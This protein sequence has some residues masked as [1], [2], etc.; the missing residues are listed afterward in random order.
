MRLQALVL[1]MLAGGVAQAAVTYAKEVSRILA[2]HCEQCHRPGDIGPMPLL[3]Y[4]DAVDYAQDIKR[5]VEAGLMPP[6]KP[7]AS[8]GVFKGTFALKPEEKADLLTWIANGTPLGNEEDLPPKPEVKGAWVLGQP[9]LTLAMPAAFTP[10]RGKDV[11]RCF[12]IPTGLDAD[13]FVS[14]VDILP[15]NRKVVHHVI[16]YLDASGEAEKLDA[17]DP[18]P[19]YDCYGGPGFDIGLSTLESLLLNGYTLGGWAPGARPDHLPA[20]VGMKLGKAA[21]IVMQV[22]YYTNVRTGE[23]RTSVGIYFNREPVQKSL[24]Y[25]PVIQTR[26]NIPAGAAA[27]VASTSFPVLPGLEMQVLSAFPHMHLLG[28]KIELEKEYRGVK[29]S[30]IL[31]DRWDFNWQGS[32]LYEKPIE[33]PAAARVNLR[34]TYDNSVNNPRNPNNPLK[35]V[36]WGEG[37]E[38]EMC[39]AFLG[40]IF[41][42]F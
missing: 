42:R 31:I 23:D 25:I 7:T 38:D 21:K 17:K 33:M 34:C 41:E 22:H 37:T 11:Y 6:W 9:D 12:V 29:E 3:T 32:Y 26:L 35:D 10:T 14:A 2:A 27:H 13:R 24:Y 16:L 40:V 19:G 1:L 5:V 8:H 4:M 39:V 20:G 18:E 15:G 30:M 36:K 28:T